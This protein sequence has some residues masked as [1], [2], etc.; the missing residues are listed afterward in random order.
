MN[1]AGAIL[2]E[3]SPAIT[4]RLAPT[5]LALALLCLFPATPAGAFSDADLI[6]GFMRS[7]FG[8][9]YPTLGWQAGVVKKYDKPVRVYVDDRSSTR[10][11]AEVA[12]FVRKLPGLID[13]LGIALVAD[14]AAANYHVFVLDRADYTSVVSREVYGRTGSTYAPG[15]CVVRVVSDA[16][17][18]SRSDAAIVA[19]EG[20]FLFRRCLVEEVLQGLG[21]VNDDTTLSESVFNDR[22]RHATFTAF[23]RHLLN[24]LYHPLIRPGMTKDEAK[25]ILP[26]VVSE[27]RARLR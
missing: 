15:K 14:P 19:D 3:P 24:M 8:S 27:V 16:A 26:R 4:M 5:A 9:E 21:P 23:D 11:G 12:A 7:V 10:R 20:D 6:D 25:E 17:G 2:H 1:D 22:S 18:I 13:G